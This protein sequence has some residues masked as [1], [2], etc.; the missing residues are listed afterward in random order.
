MVPVEKSLLSLSLLMCHLISFS[1]LTITHLLLLGLYVDAVNIHN[2][3]FVTVYNEPTSDYPSS[4]SILT[5]LPISVNPQ[6]VFSYSN[7][8]G[9]YI[10]ILQQEGG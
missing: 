1:S 3:D 5:S 10:V 8:S 4:A 6:I 7:S 2:S 9:S